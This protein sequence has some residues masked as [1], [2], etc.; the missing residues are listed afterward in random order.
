MGSLK[1]NKK[2]RR[3]YKAPA[4]KSKKFSFISFVFDFF[5]IINIVITS[6]KIIIPP[7][8]P[9]VEVDNPHS[10]VKKIGS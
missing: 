5:D 7:T 9:Y 3:K 8:I 6:N 4:K 1:P 2:E 10:F